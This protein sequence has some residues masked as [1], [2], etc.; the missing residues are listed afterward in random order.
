MSSC[1]VCICTLSDSLLLCLLPCREMCLVV[2]VKQ[3]AGYTGESVDSV[4]AKFLQ[5]S[6]YNIDKHNK[7]MK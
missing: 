3:M 5:D 6:N 4:I 1:N 7:K 2:T